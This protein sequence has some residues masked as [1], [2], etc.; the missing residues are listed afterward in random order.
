MEATDTKKADDE[1]QGVEIHKGS[2]D[3]NNSSMH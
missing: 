3:S 2:L 1:N